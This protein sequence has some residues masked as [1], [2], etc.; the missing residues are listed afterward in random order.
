[1]T[2]KSLTNI[3][4]TVDNIVVAKMSD[5]KL[6]EWQKITYTMTVNK[7]NANYLGIYTT[8]GNDMYFDDA[9]VILYGYTPVTGDN[10]MSPLAVSLIVIMSVGALL[11]VGKKVFVK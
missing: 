2:V 6:N 7:K 3:N 1:M 9:S 10:S 5:L 4:K 8:Y 11:L